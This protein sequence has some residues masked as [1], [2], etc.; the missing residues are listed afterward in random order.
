MAARRNGGNESFLTIR[1][2][3]DRLDHVLRHLAVEHDFELAEKPVS[4]VVVFYRYESKS[5]HQDMTVVVFCRRR[6]IHTAL[7]HL[8][9]EMGT[10]KPDQIQRTSER[11]DESAWKKAARRKVPAPVFSNEHADPGLATAVI[12]RKACSFW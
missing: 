2:E 5:E 10:I 9:L 1:D 12:S 6:E 8:A 3:G 4:V 11:R 7:I